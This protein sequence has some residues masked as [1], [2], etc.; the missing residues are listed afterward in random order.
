MNFAIGYFVTD[1]TVD[2]ATLGRLVEERGFEALLLAEHTHIPA[3]RETPYPAGTDLPREYWHTYD[4]FVA[5]TAA[6]LATDRLFIGT[7]I[8]LVVQ[9]DPIVVAKAA[10]S[11]DRISNGRFLFG[12]GAGWN[13]EEMRHH[14]T[15]PRRRFGL[16]RERVEAIRTIWTEDE[17]TYHG[18]HVNFDRIWSWPKP[19][20]EPGPPVLVGGNGRGVIDRVLAFGDEWFPNRIGDDEKI[21]ARVRRL[22]DAGKPTTLANAPTEPD[23]LEAYREAGVHRALWWVPPDDQGETERR[24]DRLAKVVETYNASAS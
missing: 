16:M 2:P 24:L 4:P 13:L 1:E 20:Q 12:V 11:V 21:Q 22:R 18:D 10:A 6:A 3:S 7:G 17:A 9:H 5:L 14:G 23:I 8:C 19:I 15:D